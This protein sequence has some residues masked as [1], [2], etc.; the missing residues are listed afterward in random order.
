MMTRLRRLV[1]FLSGRWWLVLLV[2][3]VNSG[4]LLVLFWLEERF[5]ALTGQPVI[6]TQNGITAAGVAEQIV[7]YSGE[8]RSA[9][10]AFAAF[11]FVFPFVGA[12][13]LAVVMSWLLRHNST[14]LAERLLAWNM[15]LVVFMSTLFDW[16][17]NVSI[18]TTIGFG[19]TAPAG[20]FTAV[21]VFKQLKLWTLSIGGGLVGLVFLFTCGVVVYG[22]FSVSRGGRG[23]G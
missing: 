14:K 5:M 21:V 3:L 13:V 15:P 16:L 19:E 10:F 6:D 9:Y 1:Q 12:L 4:S 2:I 11:D 7:L 22:R 17:E 23:R 8:A 18:V 20:L